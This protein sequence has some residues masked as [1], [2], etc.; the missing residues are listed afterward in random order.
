MGGNLNQKSDTESDTGTRATPAEYRII[1]ASAYL[2]STYEKESRIKGGFVSEKV[3]P[4]VE[5]ATCVFAGKHGDSR[6]FCLPE[7]VPV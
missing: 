7:A 4:R 3:P 2:E 1:V 5:P 6:C